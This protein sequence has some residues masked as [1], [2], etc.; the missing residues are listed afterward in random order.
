[1]NEAIVK[2]ISV[3]RQ[4][5]IDKLVDDIN[6]CQLPFFVIEPILQD[7]LNTV[8]ST[9]QKQYEMEKAQYERQ[10]KEQ[11]LHQCE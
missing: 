4:E 6:T 8:R 11:T 7:M 3:I 5:F 10:L 9:A 2:P 1:M